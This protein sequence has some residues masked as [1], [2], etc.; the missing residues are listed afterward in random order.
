MKDAYISFKGIDNLKFQKL[1]DLSDLYIMSISAAKDA[2]KNPS[3]I[4]EDLK[5]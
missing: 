3:K 4:I 2:N 1:I 5:T